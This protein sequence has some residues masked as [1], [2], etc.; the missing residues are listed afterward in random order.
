ME[1][2]VKTSKNGAYSIAF[3]KIS[4]IVVTGIILMLL[5]RVTEFTVFTKIYEFKGLDM[6]VYFASKF[7]GSLFNGTIAQ[8]F[9]IGIS[10]L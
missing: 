7:N 10:F 8:L 3:R 6:P 1:R 9:V 4:A 5:F 2:I